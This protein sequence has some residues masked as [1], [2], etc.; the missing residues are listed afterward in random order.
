MRRSWKSTALKASESWSRAAEVRR[1]IGGL[2][3]WVRELHDGE[4]GQALV[5]IREDI[6]LLEA[7]FAEG[8]RR[9][10]RTGEYRADG[11]FSAVAWLRWK[12]RL[13]GGAAMERVGVA[14]QLQ[15]LPKTEAAFSKGQV[16]YQQ[17]AAL[18]R[19][20]RNVG[21]APVQKHEGL[22]L[23]AAQSMDVDRFA[24]VTKDFEHRV[25]ADSA[26]AEANRAYARRYLHISEPINGLMRLDGLMD[27]ESGAIVKT[28]LNAVTGHDKKDERS[29][30]QKRHDALIDL[31]QRQLVTRW[32][33]MAGQRS[34]PRLVMPAVRYSRRRGG[35]WWHVT[36]AASSRVAGGPPS[37]R[38]RTTSGTGSMGD[39]R[40]SKTW[41]CCAEGT[42][43]WCTKKA[44]NWSD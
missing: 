7:A 44:G 28:A 25:D 37:G 41:R 1:Q 21:A 33:V 43:G 32:P 12:C 16:G 36:G 2:A 23:H 17:V 40:R 30:G 13:S 26:L 8:L 20:A 39:R 11:A 4:P 35:R 42:T 34:P 14:R 31:C 9:F 3:A 19:T 10:D 18:A 27:S 29:A 6:D 24:A 5:E 22:L 15:Q 38:M